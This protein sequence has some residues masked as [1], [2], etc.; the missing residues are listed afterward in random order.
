MK[1]GGEAKREKEIPWAK[2]ILKCIVLML[3]AY[4]F[5]SVNLNPLRF[6]LQVDV[7]R[8]PNFVH[9]CIKVHT[10]LLEAMMLSRLDIFWDE[11]PAK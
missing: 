5:H 8:K 4:A 3:Y 11:E 1:N 10:L 6:T 7:G 9:F 2:D